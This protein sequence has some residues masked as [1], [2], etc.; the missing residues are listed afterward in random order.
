MEGISLD[1]VSFKSWDQFFMSLAFFIGMKSKDLSTRVGSVIVTPTNRIVSVGYNGFPKGVKDDVPLRHTRPTKYFWTAHS[2][3]NSIDNARRDVDG[4]ILYTPWIPCS[5]C[6]QAIIQND[7]IEVVHC[8]NDGLGEQ[9]VGR[10]DW[11]R[12]TEES[13]EMLGEAGVKL[14]LWKGSLF[15]G[16]LFQV[17]GE[18][19]SVP[20][21]EEKSW[22]T[23]SRSRSRKSRRTDS[24]KS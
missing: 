4:C 24:P 15:H 11:K 19:I 16:G 7:I 6:A 2:E 21:R 10:A 5:W 1:D 14:R 12:S 18:K 22:R 8:Y 17:C 13:I 23:T 20:L 9:F 3:R